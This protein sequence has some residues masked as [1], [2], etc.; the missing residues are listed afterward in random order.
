MST[1]WTQT[2]MFRELGAAPDRLTIT[3]WGRR[4]TVVPSEKA[5]AEAANGDCDVVIEVV[6]PAA[7]QTQ[8]PHPDEVVH[9]DVTDDSSEDITEIVE[10]PSDVIELVYES[11]DDITVVNRDI[12]RAAAE[13]AMGARH[14]A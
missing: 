8:P 7:P 2:Y 14:G 5:R 12:A 11:G 4:F 10:A 1:M 6:G 13:P 9:V 3:A